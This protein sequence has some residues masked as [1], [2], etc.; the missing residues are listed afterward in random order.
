LPSA[1]QVA[2]FL[3][4]RCSERALRSCS[5]PPAVPGRVG[6]HLGGGLLDALA[7]GRRQVD[8]RLQVARPP[9]QTG[10]RPLALVEGLGIPL[11]R[12]V[13]APELARHAAQLAHQVVGRHAAVQVGLQQ[14]FT[15]GPQAGAFQRVGSKRDHRLA[16]VGVGDV[17]VG[18]GGMVTHLAQQGV[19]QRGTKVAPRR[20]EAG[21]FDAR[22]QRREPVVARQRG[23]ASSRRSAGSKAA[24]NGWRASGLSASMRTM[25]GAPLMITSA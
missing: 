11:Q 2:S 13:A 19:R 22:D 8:Q 1:F 6:E 24:A 10:G 12:L 20:F 7:V 5:A 23:A 17:A 25:P 16:L 9:L 14:R 18:T 21:Q 15:V 4:T 3:P